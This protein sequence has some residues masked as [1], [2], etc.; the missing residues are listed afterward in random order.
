[1]SFVDK[2]FSELLL[3]VIKIVFTGLIAE[4][5][6]MLLKYLTE[7]INFV[8]IKF[9]FDLNNKAYVSQFIQNDFRDIRGF[10]FMLLPYIDNNDLS[11]VKSLNDL[12]VKKKENVDINKYSPT[13]VYTNIQ[14]GRCNDSDGIATEIIFNEKHLDDNLLLL[15]DT[16]KL[17]SNKLYVNWTNIRPYP[18]D[19]KKTDLFINTDLMVQQNKLGFD[20]GKCMETSEFY[21]VLANYVYSDVVDIR[22]ILY[23]IVHQESLCKFMNILNMMLDIKPCIEK[24]EWNDLD[25]EKKKNLVHSGGI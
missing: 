18:L 15:K 16:I 6:L 13:Y 14:Y 1:M 21:N 10:L 23:D 11:Q 5:C 17:I 7:L 3:N 4:D 20:N 25:D 22:W 24:I 2:E 12:Y 8:A 19:F 9:N